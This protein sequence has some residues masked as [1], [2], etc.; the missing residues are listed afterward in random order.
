[1]NWGHGFMP[2]IHAGNYHP[3]DRSLE[4]PTLDGS[5][6]DL[7]WAIVEG[8]WALKDPPLLAHLRGYGT[9]VL[10]DTQAWRYGEAGTFS[11]PKCTEVP[12]APPAPLAEL[13][14]DALKDFVR[15]DLSVQ[16]QLGA[17]A[18]IV[19]GSIP[20]RHDDGI[21]KLT[22]TAVQTALDFVGNGVKPRPLI[23]FAG[24][25]TA[26]LDGAYRLLDELPYSLEAVHVQ[27]T[28]LSPMNDSPGKLVT[29]ASLLL[30]YGAKGFDVIGGRLG[31]I[32]QM[33]RAVGVSAVDAGLG[34][35][36]TFIMNS[37]LKSSSAHLGAGV[38]VPMGPR[39]Y[40]PQILRS[41]FGRDWHRLSSV[42]SIRGQLTCILP[43]CRFRRFDD[44]LNRAA[45]HSL[46]WRTEE[47]AQLATLPTTMRGQRVWDDLL[48]TRATITAIN[49]ALTEAGNSPIPHK[50]I[51]NHIATMAR[52]LHKPEAA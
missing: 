38:G 41:I 2:R 52:L 16:E 11:V 12:Y 20:R 26:D 9:Q 1:M 19:P 21:L 35:G 27:I 31:A 18:Y 32:G 28:P 34:S 50:H 5:H 37:L 49:T 10:V 48:K 24:V 22:M 39:I 6:L 7:P 33:L 17:D 44:T 42:P 23:G 43:C 4:P 14:D 15:G 8:P 36:E 29:I 25:H 13:P 51:E 40:V 3:V 45:E 46:R 47:A 30:A